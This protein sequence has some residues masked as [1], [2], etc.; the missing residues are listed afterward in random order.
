[1]GMFVALNAKVKEVGMEKFNKL[2]K[3]GLFK[4][5]GTKMGK[6]IFFSKVI[7]ITCL[8]PIFAFQKVEGK[9]FSP[10]AYTLGFALLGALITTLTL[11]PVL[12]SLLLNKN[13]REKHNHFV[14]F[15]TKIML[16][17]FIAS[18]RHKKIVLIVAGI[19]AVIGLY[20]FRYLGSEFLP[21]LNEG[22]IWLRVQLP[23]SASLQKGVDVSLQVRDKLMT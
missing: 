16:G 17:G 14:H 23:Y 4:S 3:M 9:M 12:I 20:S 21:Q 7:I 13:V 5:V 8:L 10:L 19:I 18:F 11:V 6:A 15:L 22:S 2:A 1:E